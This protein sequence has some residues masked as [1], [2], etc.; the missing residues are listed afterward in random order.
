MP[1]HHLENWLKSRS[2]GPRPPPTSF[3]RRSEWSLRK[4]ISRSSLV[5]SGLR[6]WPYHSCGTGSIPGLGTSA[7]HR[8]SQKNQNKTFKKGTCISNHLPD[9]AASADT[10]TTL[11][12]AISSKGFFPP[13]PGPHC[14][15]SRSSSRSLGQQTPLISVSKEP[16]PA[17][18][19]LPGSLP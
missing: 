9:G 3:V 8:H 16:A 2:L 17:C 5:P 1:Q 4:C 7:C 11:L 6:I 13:P 15:R 12:R 14:P 18:P 10:G 19:A